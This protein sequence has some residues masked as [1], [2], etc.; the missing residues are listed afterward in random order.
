MVPFLVNFSDAVNPRPPSTIYIIASK[1]WALT[2]F[3]KNSS[4]KNPVAISKKA[5][6]VIT[7]LL[8]GLASPSPQS[9]LIMKP[10]YLSGCSGC[11]GASLP[12]NP[13]DTA[14]VK[15]PAV[16][17]NDAGAPNADDAA[18]ADIKPVPTGAAL[19]GAGG[20]GGGV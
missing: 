14:A 9:I 6:K 4:A 1:V 2:L 20:V 11:S 17:P 13:A 5:K 10:I 3:S 16:S 15:L 8:L 19:T 18:V 12:P 7:L